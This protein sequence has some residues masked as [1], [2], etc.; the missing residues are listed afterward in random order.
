[1]RASDSILVALDV[2][3]LT[4]ADWLIRSTADYT[5][6]CKVGKQLMYSEGPSEVVRFVRER[7]GKVFMD[8]KEHDIPETVAKTLRVA[9]RMRP[10]MFNVHALGG[11]EMMRAA[12]LAVDEEAAKQPTVPKPL[13]IA[14]TIL[15]SQDMPSLVQIGMDPSSGMIHKVTELA[16]LA[17]QAGLDGVVCSPQEIMP[18]RLECGDDFVIVSAGIR[19]K[20]A[21]P[22]DQKRTATAAEAIEMGATYLVIGRPITKAADPGLAARMIAD[23]VDAV[24]V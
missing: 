21:K 1:M 8:G 16:M 19:A 20:N 13:L 24:R 18:V 11:F 12:R 17:K 14:V 22:D 4:S 5:G 2:D 9:T 10:L 6:G 15:T 23:E 7:G 3:D